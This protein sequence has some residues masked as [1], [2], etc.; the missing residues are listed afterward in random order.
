[1]KKPSDEISRHVSVD[2][3]RI[4]YRP[5]GQWRPDTPVLVFLH[6][7]L[8]SVAMWRAFPQR[9]CAGVGLPGLVYSRL[10]Y[11][12][13]DPLRGTRSMHFMHEEATGALPGLLAALGIERPVLVGHSDGASIALIHAGRF[14]GVARAVVALAPHLFVEP[15]CTAS[16]AAIT[17]EFGHSGLRER[18]ARYHD[19]VDGAFRGWSDVWL[20]APFAAWNIEAEV[21]A[22]RCPILAIQ[23]EQDQYGTMRQLDR[24]A[25]LRPDARLLKLPDCRH[26]PQFDRPDEVIAAV[27]AFLRD[28]GIAAAAVARH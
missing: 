5:I 25:E 7:G 19:D 15:V 1:M 21:A 11:G 3:R 14:P 16:I 22:S 18:L 12:R 6:E 26:S 23:G 8:G 17:A 20:S 4:E 9:L 28:V 13:S 27:G 24:I 2:G 10:G